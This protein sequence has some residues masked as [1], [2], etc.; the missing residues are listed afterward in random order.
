MLETVAGERPL[1][2]A[3]SAWLMGPF[4]RSRAVRRSR[5]EARS[6]LGD[7]GSEG[8]TPATLGP[9]RWTLQ[10]GIHDPND[11]GWGCP[12]DIQCANMPPF[13]SVRRSAEVAI[14]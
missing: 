7:P 9:L 2:R 5:L 10:R 4:E 1:A 14:R 8:L 6:S 3:R 12:N 13:G 11:L